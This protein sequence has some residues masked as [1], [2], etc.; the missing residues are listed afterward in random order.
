MQVCVLDELL[1]QRQALDGHLN[2]LRKAAARQARALI[3]K[4]R[5]AKR[6][7]RPPRRRKLRWLSA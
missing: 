5:L 3:R 7:I 4:Y 6:A 1:R 2:E